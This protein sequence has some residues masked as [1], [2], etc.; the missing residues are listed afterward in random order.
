[1]RAFEAGYRAYAAGRWVLRRSGLVRLV[2]PLVGRPMARW[3][4]GLAGS[5][6][7]P[8]R[9]QGHRM[10]LAPPGDYASPDMVGDR[11]E[12]GTT[13]LIQALVR[14]GD[15]VLDIGAHVGYY[16]LLAARATGPT[17]RVY[18]FEPAPGNFELLT[19]NIRLNGYTQIAAVHRAISDT[20]GPRPLFISRLDNGFHSLFRLGLPEPAAPEAV[21]VQTMTL[22]EFLAAQGWPTVQ[23]VKLDIEG[24]ETAAF[25]GMRQ[26]LAR[27]PDLALIIEFCPWILDTLGM[28]PEVF[29]DGL[30]AEGFALHLVEPDRVAPLAD[31]EV[32]PLIGRLL[33]RDGYAN[34]LCVRGALAHRLPGALEAPVAAIR[35]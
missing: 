28:R 1:M 23:V 24:G 20:T 27:S 18:A 9:I 14:P 35:P 29:L 3:V 17:G 5:G 30:R 6:A 8:L 25:Q 26:F 7:Q 10:V 33:R 34:L 21:M 2:R 15:V 22:D 4:Y 16:S 19:Q 32:P 12:P 11:Y 31:A 13:R